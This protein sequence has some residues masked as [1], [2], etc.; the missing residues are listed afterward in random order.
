[1][2]LITLGACNNVN[3]APIILNNPKIMGN[4]IN[5]LTFLL[6]NVVLLIMYIW[7]KSFYSQF[8][9]TALTNI[10]ICPPMQ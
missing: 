10:K 9:S 7:N 3:S 4:F 1:M 5:M 2:R 8:I 6:Q